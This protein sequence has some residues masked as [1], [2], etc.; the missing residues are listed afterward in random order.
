MAMSLS[1]TDAKRQGGLAR[2]PYPG[3]KFRRQSLGMRESYLQDY[4]VDSCFPF[5]EGFGCGLKS[6]DLV[7][8]T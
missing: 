8:F 6:E 3:P 1:L 7:T 4:Q 2:S 5:S